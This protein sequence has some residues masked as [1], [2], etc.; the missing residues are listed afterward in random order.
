VSPPAAVR[1]AEAVPGARLRV[2]PGCGHFAYL[3]RP[4][5]VFA[6]ISTLLTAGTGS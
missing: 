3:E 6:E 1:I 5:L 2:L 4:D